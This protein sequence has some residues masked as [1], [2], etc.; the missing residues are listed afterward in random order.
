MTAT[1][2]RNKAVKKKDERK[3]KASKRDEDAPPD[4]FFTPQTPEP[5]PFYN[6][7]E[8]WNRGVVPSNKTLLAFFTTWSQS[9]ILANDSRLSPAGQSL[10]EDLKCMG[11]ILTRV[12][13]ERNQDEL[14]QRFVG[15]LRLAGRVLRS[16]RRTGRVT[17]VEDVSNGRRVNVFG[18]R[19]AQIGSELDSRRDSVRHDAKELMSLGQLVITSIDFRGLLSEI[20]QLVRRAINLDIITLPKEKEKEKETFNDDANVY[21]TDID[22]PKALRREGGQPE[23]IASVTNLQDL[24]QRL[25]RTA[26]EL[27]DLKRQSLPNEAIMNNVEKSSTYTNFKHTIEIYPPGNKNLSTEPTNSMGD[28]ISTKEEPASPDA[29]SLPIS[30]VNGNAE[31]KPQSKEPEKQYSALPISKSSPAKHREDSKEQLLNDAKVVFKKVSENPDFRNAMIQ[32]WAIVNRWQREANLHSGNVLPSGLQYDAN[33]SAAQQDLI[34]LMER[35]S[36]GATLTPLIKSLKQVNDEA[37]HD[38]ELSDFLLD[39][40]SFLLNCTA[41]PQYLEHEEYKLRGRFLLDRTTDYADRK[42]RKVFQ[43]NLDNWNVFLEGWKHDK[44][45]VEL[46]KTLSH[47]VNQDIFGNAMGSTSPARGLLNL[48]AIQSS[49][50]ADLRNV[51]LPALLR[52]LYELPLPHLEIEQAGMKIALDNI[53]LPATMFAPANLNLFT[54]SALRMT[55]RERLLS[56]FARRR[57]NR[58]VGTA[59]EGVR[60]S[61]GAHLS[62]SGMKGDIPGIHFAVD[63]RKWPRV[64]DQG[65]CDVRLGGKGLS[66]NVDVATDISAAERRFHIEPIYVS[67]TLHRLIMKFD[68]LKQHTMFNVMR[69]YLQNSMKSRIERTICDRIVG[70]IQ[71]ID[72]IANRLAK[73]VVVASSQ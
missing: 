27:Q 42:Y 52:S 46:G 30:E 11:G 9:T 63:R 16:N 37:S 19:D 48:A 67:V 10:V 28:Q 18:R 25:S 23:M 49:L 50:V 54:R 6:F 53:V 1:F 57:G 60:W 14:V 65:T 45:T 24:E 33:F 68:D 62:L 5:F 72:K 73:G 56:G 20:Q 12:I 26:E 36:G 4:D 21:S 17:L 58:R 8:D 29:E 35:F 32:G 70:T 22:G 13:K 38:Y 3:K 66:L 61:S 2:R 41:E 39:W 44:L 7:L 69:P 31:S 51:M 34:E 64:R 47:I 59:D 15:H 71:Q 43:E 55:P 40:R